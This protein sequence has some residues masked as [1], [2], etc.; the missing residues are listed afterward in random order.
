MIAIPQN[1]PMYDSDLCTIN[2]FFDSLNPF[3]TQTMY[4]NSKDNRPIW[5]YNIEEK[6][7]FVREGGRTSRCIEKHQFRGGKRYFSPIFKTSTGCIMEDIDLPYTARFNKICDGGSDCPLKNEIIVIGLGY[8][9]SYD[10]ELDDD[11]DFLPDITQ[12][13]DTRLGITETPIT[14]PIVPFLNDCCVKGGEVDNSVLK[15]KYKQ[16]CT[17]NTK[18]EISPKKFKMIMITL[19]FTQKNNPER[20]WENIQILPSNRAE[21]N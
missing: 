13:P 7:I 21:G 6:V 17:E 16:W 10:D 18:E 3:Y 15:A 5:Q 4:P 8:H 19:G 14:A 2:D 9:P 1:A 11:G 20:T 12:E